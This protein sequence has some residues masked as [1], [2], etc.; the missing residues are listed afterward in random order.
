MIHLERGPQ[1]CL[2]SV[3]N[4]PGNA[5]MFA[6]CLP[7]IRVELVCNELRS[8]T[9]RYHVLVI[10]TFLHSNYKSVSLSPSETNSIAQMNTD[11]QY[12]LL[13]TDRLSVGKSPETRFP[14]VRT[15]G[16]EI[17]LGCLIKLYC[18]FSTPK[19]KFGIN[20]RLLAQKFQRLGY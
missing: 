6:S 9:T 10:S 11:V 7:S 20:L 4:G 12:Q 15:E 5:Q 1:V 2:A 14:K 3:P 16:Y 18:S 13:V 19:P 17:Y 8:S